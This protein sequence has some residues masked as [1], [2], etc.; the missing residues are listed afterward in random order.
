MENIEGQRLGRNSSHP[1]DYIKRHSLPHSTAVPDRRSSNRIRIP[2]ASPEVISSL[3]ST[4]SAISSPTESAS[5]LSIPRSA[6]TVPNSPTFP[7]GF[8]ANGSPVVTGG[9]GMDYGAYNQSEKDDRLH[10]DDAAI[11][12]VV[13]TAPRPRPASSV[14]TAPKR[15]SLSLSYRSGGSKE[16]LQVPEDPGTPR[17]IGSVSIEPGVRKSSASIKSFGSGKN[18]EL[19]GQ[20]SLDFKSSKGKMREMDRE[21]KRKTAKTADNEMPSPNPS[22]N[23][24]VL[25]SNNWNANNIAASEGLGITS[26]QSPMRSTSKQSS[27]AGPSTLRSHDENFESL[28][29]PIPERDS[30]IRHSIGLTTTARRKR[31][32]HRSEYNE[33]NDEQDK[34]NGEAGPSQGIEIPADVQALEKTPND[35]EEDDVS[36]RIKELKSQKELRDRQRA[37]EDEQEPEDPGKRAIS[38]RSSLPASL[39]SDLIQERSSSSA[40]VRNAETRKS[41]DPQPAPQTRLA[42]QSL[43]VNGYQRSVSVDGRGK[44]SST[45]PRKRRA[46]ESQ[47]MAQKNSV[48]PPLIGP[49][50][51]NTTQADTLVHAVS[52]PTQFAKTKEADVRPSTADSID[53]E[54]EAY[55]SLP[56]LSQRVQHQQTGRVISYSDVGDSNGYVVFCC[57]G[58]GLT[59]YLTA[60]YDDL[61]LSLKL[62]LITIDRPG[63][64]GS[65]PITD[66]TD[67]PLGWADDVRTVC[68][69]LS[70]SRFSI[71]AHSAGA[72][73]ALATA[74]R[75]PQHIRGRIHL[76][77]PWIPPSQLSPIGI[78]QEPLPVTTIPYSQ[79]LLRS[80]PTPFLKAANSNFFS[81]TSSSI[82]TSLPKS[83]RRSKRKSLTQDTLLANGGSAPIPRPSRSDSRMLREH[84]SGNGLNNSLIDDDLDDLRKSHTSLPSPNPN[85]SNSK[86]RQQDYDTRLTHAIWALATLNANP[87]VDLLVCLERR[88]DI[89]FR[90]V[91]ITKAVVIHHGSRDSRVPVE[92]VKWLGKTMRRCE[93]RVLPGEGHGL[94]AS[95]GVMGAVLTEMSREW[96]DWNVVVKG[97]KGKEGE[98]GEGKSPRL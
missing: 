31:K 66:G 29:L 14:F 90:Y 38:G 19:K 21:R 78:H 45:T 12:P 96:E 57:V 71:L 65:E 41:E 60:F 48:G 22:R 25:S 83:P 58:M 86:E 10:P 32:S 93:V 39:P 34:E 80:L 6:R 16:N 59:R 67:T 13:R 82:T 33:V 87:A 46:F 50:P 56:R 15:G 23:M 79:R 40:A 4:L 44:S 53:D 24:T 11:P 77:A 2:P 36:R 91:D 7:G 47:Y 70:I 97:R 95:A 64:G 75:M 35:P 28:G 30:S 51:A 26:P 3:I 17:S 63:V 88:Q 43:A 8:T 18:S 55:L 5:S 54:V 42:M 94:M 62:R 9:W 98:K 74:L 76:L 81:A 85:N 61:A 49:K 68:Q 52:A 84:P 37:A 1:H 73:Y 27:E 92:N 20:R 72:I 89:G 69:Q